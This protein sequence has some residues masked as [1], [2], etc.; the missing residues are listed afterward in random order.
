MK[1]GDKK[2]IQ[3]FRTPTLTPVTR[4]RRDHGSTK[5]LMNCAAGREQ[6][7]QVHISVFTDKDLLQIF[8]LMA[9]TFSDLLGVEGTG[10]LILDQPWYHLPP[11]L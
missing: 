4:R 2:M 3:D 7:W 10:L 8:W 9:F 11:E 5:H 1:R 6:R